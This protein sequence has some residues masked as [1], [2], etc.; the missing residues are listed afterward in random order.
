MQFKRFHAPCI[1]YISCNLTTIKLR[2]NI[3]NFCLQ[4]NYLNVFC[5]GALLTGGALMVTSGHH[6]SHV[7]DKN[8]KKGIYR[9]K[10]SFKSPYCFTKFLCFSSI[11]RRLIMSA[12]NQRSVCRESDLTCRYVGKIVLLQ[13]MQDSFIS[14][15]FWLI[16]KG[17]IKG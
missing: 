4:I 13:R 10:L 6:A 5:I 11:I 1:I 17:E 12:L 15:C 7:F 3:Y 14:C 9:L 2:K 8:T 16:L